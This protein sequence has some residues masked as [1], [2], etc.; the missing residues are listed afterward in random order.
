LTHG[1]GEPQLEPVAEADSR[2]E[3]RMLRP[4]VTVLVGLALMSGCGGGD[5][6]EE[7]EATVEGIDTAAMIAEGAASS[8]PP[9]E[10]PSFVPI[11]VRYNARLLHSTAAAAANKISL[12]GDF[13]ASGRGTCRVDEQAGTWQVELANIDQGNLQSFRTTR[14]KPEGKPFVTNFL[15]A[16]GEM[17]VFQAAN[18]GKDFLDKAV[19]TPTRTGGGATLQFDV[20]A[21]SGLYAVK[22]TATCAKLSPPI[23]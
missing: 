17:A 9:V 15:S 12:G 4:A 1:R 22:G 6:A 5:D 18:D 7:S 14:W 16:A 2:A 3:V 13:S 10:D 19:M 21:T 20:E 8:Q 23:E 11:D